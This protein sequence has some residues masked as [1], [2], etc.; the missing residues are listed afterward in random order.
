MIV[1]PSGSQRASVRGIGGFIGLYV[2]CRSQ[3]HLTHMEATL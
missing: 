2:L 1:L 3:M